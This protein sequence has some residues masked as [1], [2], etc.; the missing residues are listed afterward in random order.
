MSAVTEG[1]PLEPTGDNSYKFL[2]DFVG[3]RVWVRIHEPGGDKKADVGIMFSDEGISIDV[4]DVE[5]E[6]TYLD[7]SG[8]P[9]LQPYLL[10]NCDFVAGEETEK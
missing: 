3:T 6:T 10:W 5:H 8:D 1:L 4:Y 2:E 9:I 7:G